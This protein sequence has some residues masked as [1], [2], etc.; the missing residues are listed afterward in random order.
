MGDFGQNSDSLGGQPVG[1]P[2]PK[3]YVISRRGVLGG[4][5]AAPAALA[6]SK[7][8]GAEPQWYDL[9]FQ[10]SSD[11]EAVTV[12]E[13]MVT[14]ATETTPEKR[15]LFADWV[16]P[17]RAFG[18][19]AFFDMKQPGDI[20][21]DAKNASSRTI[22]VRNIA[23]GTRFSQTDR[24]GYVAFFF[25][26]KGLN[27]TIAYLTN[28]WLSADGADPILSSKPSPFA[29][30]ANA[31]D[32][33]VARPLAEPRPA[34]PYEDVSAARVGRTLSAAFDDRIAG[35]GAGIFQVSIN[36]K[37][38]WEI[39]AR[40]NA[41]LTAMRGRLMLS[42]LKVA[43]RE[44]AAGPAAAAAAPAQPVPTT[45]G[46]AKYSKKR[47]LKPFSY[48]S[49]I[50][51]AAEESLKGVPHLYL[52]KPG[53]AIVVGPAN[54]HRIEL[55]AGGTLSL[56]LF[57]GAASAKPAERQVV[58]RLEMGQAT[59]SV[60]D[61]TALL[62][63]D[64][65][66]TALALTQTLTPSVSGGARVLRTVLSAAAAGAR[67]TLGLID[68]SEFSP[69]GQIRTLVGT[70]R[71]ARKLLPPP[72]LAEP[73]EEGATPA[74]VETDTEDGL[75]RLTRMFQLAN[76]DRMGAPDAA[77]YVLHDAPAKTPDTGSIRRITVDLALVGVHVALP[78]TSYSYLLFK[79]SELRLAFADGQPISELLAGEYPVGAASSYVW[80]GPN[81]G[82][83]RAS[84]NLS[85]AT[86]TCARDYDLM[87]LRL[88]FRDL[89]L[90]YEP[91]PMIR[92]AR[93]DARV[94][95]DEDG[96]V[97]DERAIL[98]AEFDPQHVMEEA[99]FR[100]QAPPLPDVDLREA[101]TVKVEGVDRTVRERHQI[102]EA[103]KD[104]AKLGERVEI[105][106]LVKQA[107]LAQEAVDKPAPASQPFRE[108]ATAF[109]AALAPMLLGGKPISGLPDDQKI[110]I[111][112]FGLDPDAM[113]T[114]RLLMQDIGPATVRAAL[115]DSLGKAAALADQAGPLGPPQAGSDAIKADVL[116]RVAGVDATLAAI[117]AARNEAKFEASLPLYRVFRDYW[118][119]RVAQYRSSLLDNKTTAA[120]DQLGFERPVPDY[121]QPDP[122][123]PERP[124]RMRN[125]ILEFY[126]PNNR[127][128]D[129]PNEAT[130]AE[131]AALVGEIKR[132]FTFFALGMDPVPDLTGA[133]LSGR[134]RLAFRLETEAYQGESARESGVEPMPRSSAGNA[135]PAASHYPAIPFTFEALTDWS[136]HE[137]VV[138]KRARK[139][140]EALQYGVLPPPGRRAANPSDQAM[141]RYQGFTEAPT[142]SDTRMAE[143][144]ASLASDR[145]AELETGSNRPFPGEPLDTE[146]A[147][148]IP[149]RLILSTAQDAVW[150][151]NRR[152]PAA[153]FP[154]TPSGE[155]LEEGGHPEQDV[156][157]SPVPRDLWS[158]RLETSGNSP[159][160]RAVASPDLRPSALGSYR[161][162]DEPRL[163][164]QGAPPRG[165]YAPWFVG[166]EQM[167]SGTVLPHQIAGTA[168][169]Q[170][171]C[172]PG[173]PKIE[174]VRWLCER[175]GFRQALPLDDFQIFRT[176]LDAFDRHQLV[177][178]SS[179]YG[180]PVIG[181]RLA[182]DP[183]D[184][185]KSGALISGSGQIEPGQSFKLL[186]ATEDQA[187]HKPV[188]LKVKALSLSA[189]GGSFLHDTAFK[190]SAGAD[191]YRGRKIFEGFSI[192]TLQ[193]DIV[194]GRD[195]RTEVIYKGYLLPLGHKASFVK[196]T[197]RIFLRTPN[198]GIKAMLR[199]RMFLR[200]SEP[201]KRYGALG[202]PHVGRMWCGKEVR[203]LA[204]KTPDLLDP[205]FAIDGEP[206]EEQKETLNGRIWLGNGPGLAFW[207][208]TDITDRGLYRFE[209][210]IDGTPTELPMLFVDN[211]AATT[212]QSL[213][214]AAEHYNAAAERRILQVRGRKINFA[215]N[216][217]SGEA[218]FETDWLRIRAHG[219]AGTTQASTW[220]GELE[221]TRNFQTTGVLEGA[222]QPPFYPS[223]EEASIRL[224]PVERMSGANGASVSVQYDGHY[225]LYGFAGDHVARGLPA[226]DGK[227]ANPHDVFLTL[228]AVSSLKLGGNGDRAGGIARP[229]SHIVAISRKNGPMGGDE[230]TYWTTT[231]TISGDAK[232]AVTQV[233]GLPNCKTLGDALAEGGLGLVSLAPYFNK[234]V[235]RATVTP[236]EKQEE[237][238]PAPATGHTDIVKQVQSF[239][240][241]DAKLLG[242]IRLKTLM[243]L[244]DI[245][246]E[247]SIPVLKEVHEFGTGALE[248]VEKLDGDLR[249]RVLLPLRDVVT[250]LL[251]EWSKLDEKLKQKQPKQLGGAK[252]LSIQ[253]IYPEVAVGLSGL[254]SALDTALA[255]DNSAALAGQLP[256]IHRRAV[257]LIRGLAAVA[258]DPVERL[259]DAL[260][261]NVSERIAALTS[262][263][264]ALEQLARDLAAFAKGL[265][266]NATTAAATAITDWIFEQVAESIPH[267][268]GH[269]IQVSL[270]LGEVLP[271]SSLPPDMGAIVRAFVENAEGYLGQTYI[272]IVKIGSDLGD[273]IREE[274]A[275]ALRPAVQR[276][277]E[278][279]LKGRSAAEAAQAAL[280]SY[281][282]KLRTEVEAAREE[283]LTSVRALDQSISQSFA[284]AK[285]ALIKALEAYLNDFIEEA[286]EDKIDEFIASNPEDVQARIA[287]LEWLNMVVDN[288]RTLSNAIRTGE[289]K[290]IL[291]AG[292]AFAQNVLG[293][294]FTEVNDA[295]TKLQ[296]DLLS[297]AK[298]AVTAVLQ[299]PAFANTAELTILQREIKG[300]EALETNPALPGEPPIK[301]GNQVVGSTAALA[302]IGSALDSLIAL[303]DIPSGPEGR[304]TEIRKKV[305]SERSK[306]D[307]AANEAI[308]DDTYDTDFLLGF[309]DGT[310]ETIVGKDAANPA[311]CLIADLRGLYGDIVDVIVS[312]R[313]LQTAFDDLDPA[314][315]DL[316]K[317]SDALAAMVRQLRAAT[318]SIPVRLASIVARLQ[319][320]RGK[321][322]KFLAVV[323][324]LAGLV[325][326]L[327]QY[328]KDT[329]LLEN[330]R[331]KLA[332]AEK[333]LANSLATVANATLRLVGGATSTASEGVALVVAAA[334]ELKTLADRLRLG[335][336]KEI[337]ALEGSLVDL[338]AHFEKFGGLAIPAP[339]PDTIN[340]LLKAAIGK[341]DSSDV[342]LEKFLAV[343]QDTSP[344]L[345]AASQ[346]RQLEAAVLQ[347]LRALELRIKGAPDVLKARAEDLLAGTGLFGTL[348]TGY[349]SV[350]TGRDNLVEELSSSIFL[351]PLA[352]KALIVPPEPMLGPAV[353]NCP[354][355]FTDAIPEELQLA[356]DRLA[357]EAAVLARAQGIAG[358]QPEERAPLRHS[359]VAFFR[360]WGLGT[361]APLVIIDQS[362]ELA[363]DLLRGNV[364][365]AIDL[366]AFRD[367]LEDAIA[368][369]IP[370]S[371]SFSYD[372]ASVV[373]SPPDRSKAIFQP[374]L[375]SEFG[376]TLRASFDLL[377]QRSSFAAT[378]FIGPF[379]IY[380]IG[381]VVDALRLKFG[382]AAFTMRDKASPRFDVI[383]EDFEIGKQLEFAQ[384]LQSYLSPKDG[385]VFIQ[386]MTRAAGIEAGYGINLGTI[387]FG[388]TSFF[389][390]TLNVS[391]ELP[392]DDSESLFKVSLGRRLAPFTMGV[393][394]FV[395][396]GY[397]AIFAAA[398][399]IRGFEAS[400]EYGGGAAI[401]Y[402]PL[403]ADVRVQVGV[404]VR[405]LKTDKGKTT[406]I[407][408]TFFAGGSASIWIFHFATSL[409]VRLGTA[410]DG[411]MYGEAIYTFSFSIGFA[412]YDYS[413]RVMKEEKA[414]GSGGSGQGS[415][416][417]GS[418]IR[419]AQGNTGT[420]S[421]ADAPV[422][423]PPYAT[424]VKA[425][426]QAQDWDVYASYFDP[427]L[428]GESA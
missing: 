40:E 93:E 423:P 133:R 422:Q 259:E 118:R 210:N 301:K 334:G 22:F 303:I 212:A 358:I 231:R 52:S 401:G 44:F 110:Y 305:E 106:R 179:T 34:L 370:T 248:T 51:S 80:V 92:P 223:M 83:N 31:G 408:G 42:A 186:D 131:F 101:I 197:E 120:T 396:S 168:S 409:Y 76:G 140:Y 18:P 285:I 291:S 256:E 225:V 14:P 363:K 271:F 100:P 60:A 190:P 360:S 418:R 287:G 162:G 12:A 368:G 184:V 297:Q 270:L 85:R 282:V 279:L 389:N 398:D 10:I 175:L 145:T 330:A 382:G 342:T 113:A 244:L 82:P 115:E 386:P 23:F 206:I 419:V 406:E 318:E 322:G 195:I 372:F 185:E 321:Y 299:D 350:K 2:A 139:L 78:D 57:V 319:A 204:D 393:F 344:Y 138:T 157:H 149:A 357:Q 73:D 354:P 160:L 77:L 400:F 150:R 198:Q 165:P 132:Q 130:D 240:S 200:M 394:P 26:R 238:F 407:Y 247:S 74:P 103:L 4:I 104:A 338:R 325:A 166:P 346:L 152:L 373:S 112:A 237:P 58:S 208:R 46:S 324:G 335:L 189:L 345:E 32:L 65:G 306:I 417:D 169:D 314:N 215:P 286:V 230:S 187:I 377:S 177:L 381:G 242:T 105:R 43:W 289:P 367:Q 5:A 154:D 348:I 194:L 88:R 281:L 263:I 211:I 178:L 27:W 254:Q 374:H 108:M 308:G 376:I 16:I 13:I 311:D 109:E 384:K 403:S 144:R 257:D 163:P 316:R 11:L 33:D 38:V 224:G 310:R 97:H 164:G 302:Q 387:G 399:G 278:D 255:T 174:I 217:R 127:P 392:F 320:Y 48:F 391:A 7:V 235:P 41:R 207:P 89:V 352:R 137:L 143:V 312:T 379:D 79:R 340:G 15:E 111:G 333:W 355:E 209:I 239:F 167:E 171:A 296:T 123:N 378:A 249:R 388:A 313:G 81:S 283:A 251:R 428:L 274:S 172:P 405:V 124:G 45:A 307:Q 220:T 94:R 219:R 114:A 181:K 216:S 369:L 300:L 107:K 366:G 269:D 304:L 265:P 71:V 55:N 86:L 410:A 68:T 298:T 75:L 193:Q 349:R 125:L 37:F 413:I 336:N 202:Q 201:L 205:T 229:E 326:L 232:P 59:L 90:V 375:G 241:L 188:P 102:Q 119:D 243:R 414:I 129:Y 95:I 153:L 19:D 262:S 362:E 134:T 173:A 8:L 253:D 292:G 158:V 323:G 199:Q 266:D 116:L 142:T 427:N 135:G 411:A 99:I 351:G 147:I 288:A 356:C 390:V 54:G 371:V 424:H 222:G 69:E 233:D 250:S 277:I 159:G 192:D 421:D 203:L 50:S 96:S 329:T 293:V 361:S 347:Q 294:D 180:L 9:E 268:P 66:A 35:S 332:E 128:D 353:E 98:I 380:L 426:G 364:F 236:P 146:T 395:G 56:E 67:T 176:S 276:A 183:E 264:S 141:L 412:D 28:I 234:E 36:S 295:L 245:I 339:P 61:K 72:V 121:L 227:N 331:A 155:P 53:E 156:T 284:A 404:F 309:I 290:A 221:D 117:N 267:G 341:L 337:D 148:E 24:R 151:T 63:G 64:I 425:V 226:P 17:A 21:I 1:K 62:A 161:G 275:K 126:S 191:D 397:F 213:K 402:G 182:V 383:Y 29:A 359:I 122:S 246:D 6:A 47:D 416:V 218:R 30:F 84:F 272:D 196:L 415:L 327:R 49:G 273:K 39:V 328:L 260:T 25:E 261:R 315:P 365:A 420:A 136:R 214:A 170:E 252:P 87:K 70:L 20:P 91:Q 228:R 343:V 317:F 3:R 385:G 258:N 280:R